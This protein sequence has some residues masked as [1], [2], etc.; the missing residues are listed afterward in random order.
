MVFFRIVKFN[1][2][3]VFTQEKLR[4]KTISEKYVFLSETWVY[5]HFVLAGESPPVFM[6]RNHISKSWSQLVLSCTAE[7]EG[8]LILASTKNLEK[9]KISTKNAKKFPR[10]YCLLNQ[11]VSRKFFKIEVIR[12]RRRKVT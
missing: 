8:T 9:I 11:S 3:I 12:S 7:E 6:E 10:R 4:K 1:N 2:F 5:V